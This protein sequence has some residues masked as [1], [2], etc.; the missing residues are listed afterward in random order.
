MILRIETTKNSNFTFELKNKYEFNIA[1]IWAKYELLAGTV[2]KIYC[3][4]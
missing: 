4:I 2:K 1:M 3:K